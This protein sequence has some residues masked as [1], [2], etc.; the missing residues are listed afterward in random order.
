MNATKS[1]VRQA[2]RHSVVIVL[3]VV[4]VGV[5][6]WGAAKAM[7]R[8]RVEKLI[9]QFREAPTNQRAAKLAEV[10]QKGMASKKQQERIEAMLAEKSEPNLAR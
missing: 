9:T 6:M 1:A 3:L 7:E 2:V 8:G 5:L 4:M 10:V